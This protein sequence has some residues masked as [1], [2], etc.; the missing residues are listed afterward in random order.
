MPTNH[1][2]PENNRKRSPKARKSPIVTN[3]TWSTR[4]LLVLGAHFALLPRPGACLYDELRRART[5]RVLKAALRL[6][7]HTAVRI[8]RVTHRHAQV[9]ISRRFRFHSGNAVRSIRCFRPDVDGGHSS[10]CGR[11]EF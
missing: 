4:E 2:L 11:E 1:D 9:E 6:N 5:Q 10:A 7:L 8:I 3:T